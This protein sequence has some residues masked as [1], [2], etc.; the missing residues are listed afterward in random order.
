MDVTYIA[1]GQKQIYDTDIVV[2]AIASVRVNCQM[3]Y[4]G[5]S[6]TFGGLGVEV[7]S[8]DVVQPC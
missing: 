3:P 7:C 1:Y 6:F 8:L 5:F 4:D 2:C